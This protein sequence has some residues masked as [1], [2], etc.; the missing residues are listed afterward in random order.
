M[1]IIDRYIAVVVITGTLTALLVVVGLDVFFSLIGQIEDVGEGGYTLLKM[2]ATVVL[3]I[4]NGM[5]ELFPVP[6]CWAVLS[7]WECWH[8][9]VS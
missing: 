2:L 4:P 6:R 9:I 7:A 1:K 5:Y 3:T 8:R